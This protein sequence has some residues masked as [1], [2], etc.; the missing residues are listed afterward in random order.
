MTTK[1][2]ENAIPC[3]TKAIE[4]NPKDPAFFL[5]RALCHLR[6]EKFEAAI[7]DC[8]AALAL[9]NKL[10]KAYFRRMQSHTK[11]N[12][13]D[14]A[15]SDCLMMI[16]M[17]AKNP[18]LRKEFDRIKQLKIEHE[19][20]GMAAQSNK[21]VLEDEEVAWEPKPKKLWSKFGTEEE[22]VRFQ[23]K[24]PHLRSKVYIDFCLLR[25]QRV[26]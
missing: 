7:E 24:A 11:L 19:S 17:D 14:R 8:D 16:R 6:L 26:L 21:K 2:Y 3:Y 9:D 12:N 20:G 22:E 25:K 10:D 13:F 1:D 18:N 4:L 23:D 15:L 5:N